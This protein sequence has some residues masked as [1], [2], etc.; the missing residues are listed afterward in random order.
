M[1]S[2]AGAYFINNNSTKGGALYIYVPDDFKASGTAFMKNYADD[3]G[4]G[5]FLRSEDYK[6]NV[7]V[8]NYH[9]LEGCLFVDNGAGDGGGL[10]QDSEYFGFSIKSSVFERNYAGESV[11]PT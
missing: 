3:V 1:S 5:L 9:L 7:D 8:S 4:G 10:Y 6:V 2:E 11:D